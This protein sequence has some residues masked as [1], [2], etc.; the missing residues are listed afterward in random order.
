MFGVLVNLDGRTRS[1]GK[2]IV[3]A[4]KRLVAEGK[5]KGWAKRKKGKP[6]YPERFFI[7]V[8][9]KHG[10]VEN[11]HYKR[12]KKEGIWF[13][14]FAFEDKR[15]ALEIDGKQH[16]QPDRMKK[17]QKKDVFLMKSGWRVHRIPWKSINNSSSKKYMKGQ[18]DTLLKLLA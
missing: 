16:Q 9:A 5:H 7:G 8:L 18:I 13:V 10:Y 3:N 14:D 11:V 15:F 4:Q 12:D 1:I 17:D 2:K 6:S